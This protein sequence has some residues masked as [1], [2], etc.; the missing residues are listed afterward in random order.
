MLASQQ[1]LQRQVQKYTSLISSLRRLD[2]EDSVILLNRLRGG[3]YDGVL[4]RN[5]TAFRM[6]SPPKEIHPWEYPLGQ[7][8]AHWELFQDISS[9]TGTCMPLQDYVGVPLVPYSPQKPSMGPRPQTLGSHASTQAFFTPGMS[10]MKSQS[11]S[12][13]MDVHD[14]DRSLRFR[15]TTKARDLIHVDEW[16]IQ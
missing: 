1:N 15:S 8:E 13:P 14:P 3:D 16:I 11:V 10:S 2:I 12:I 5:D 9:L 4:F 6:S 7:N